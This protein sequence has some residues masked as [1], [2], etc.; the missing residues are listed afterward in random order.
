MSPEHGGTTVKR[1][2]TTFAEQPSLSALPVVDEN[3]DERMT[4]QHVV[5]EE[6]RR[7]LR[8]G[9]CGSRT[10]ANDDRMHH[11][12]FG[13]SATGAAD[14]A[15]CLVLQESAAA[16][17]SSC[18]V[19]K[20]K[21]HLTDERIELFSRGFHLRTRRSGR[22]AKV[23]VRRSDVGECAKEVVLRAPPWGPADPVVL[24]HTVSA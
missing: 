11:V 7:A 24:S 18:K 21:D 16:Y 13:G 20:L 3:L 19:C 17:G 9:G 1:W 12:G 23:R 10:G 4:H 14:Q 22:R 6:R 15:D 5:G 2:L 8:N